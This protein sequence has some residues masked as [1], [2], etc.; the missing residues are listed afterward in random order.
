VLAVAVGATVMAQGVTAQ[1]DR[2]L[3]AL[4]E[5]VRL[6]RMAVEK[7]TTSQT[8]LQAIRAYVAG[9]RS[10]MKKRRRLSTTGLWP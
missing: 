4:T 6:L 9:I 10:R 8:Q 3:T 2:A 5:E 7:S 1:P